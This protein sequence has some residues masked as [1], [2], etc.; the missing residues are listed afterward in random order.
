[1]LPLLPP[2]GEP[3]D[4]GPGV[5]RV[6]T[7]QPPIRSGERLLIC[8]PGLVWDVH[9]LVRDDVDG[10]TVLVVQV[11]QSPAGPLERY[12]ALRRATPE[13]YAALRRATPERYAALRRATP[14]RYAALRPSATPECYAALRR[15][16]PERYAALRRATP[17]RYAALR[18]SLTWGYTAVHTGHR[19][20]PCPR[21]LN[22]G[23]A[24]TPR[25]LPLSTPPFTP[26]HTHAE[27]F[28]RRSGTPD[29]PGSGQRHRPGGPLRSGRLRQRPGDGADG[30]GA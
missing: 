25:R 13:R 21:P 27:R 30:S 6:E 1:M 3:S 24:Y 20:P 8:R 18:R 16:T 2:R 4:A 10:Y 12:A 26:V 14:E 28:T 5:G 15:A 29:G 22:R 9:A 23:Q 17:D 11:R 19:D 7:E